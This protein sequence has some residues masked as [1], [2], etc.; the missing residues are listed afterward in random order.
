MITPLFYLVAWRSAG[1]RIAYFM[2][3][4]LSPAPAPGRVFSLPVS[5]SSLER[6]KTTL[7]LPLQPGFLAA[8]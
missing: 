6:L 4:A 8:I 2:V 3:G 7:K 1:M 5:I